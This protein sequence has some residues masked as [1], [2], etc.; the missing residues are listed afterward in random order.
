MTLPKELT[1]HQRSLMQVLTYCQGITP[2]E[3]RQK[4]SLSYKELAV[5]CQI[6]LPT[7]KRWFSNPPRAA[8]TEVMKTLAIAD[9]ILEDRRAEILLLQNCTQPET[10]QQE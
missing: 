7:V 5:L 9:L 3:F 8:S 4:W 6:S 2:Q 1:K 10:N